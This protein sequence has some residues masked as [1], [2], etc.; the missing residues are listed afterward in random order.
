MTSE[1]KD[2]VVRGVLVFLA[3]FFALMVLIILGI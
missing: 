2:A 3:V 1:T